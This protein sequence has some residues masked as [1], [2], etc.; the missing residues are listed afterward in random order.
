MINPIEQCGSL[1]AEIRFGWHL[2]NWCNYKCS[3]CTVYDTITNDFTIDAHTKD[4][5][6]TL[7]KL[8]LFDRP[9]NICLTGGETSLHPRIFEII[10]ELSK[11]QMLTNIWFFTN[12]S[13]SIKFYQQLNSIKSNKI[14]LYASYH[15]EYH[16]EKFIEKCIILNDKLR[17]SVHLSLSD[18]PDTWENT[19]SVIESLRKNNIECRLNLL[20]PTPNWKPNYDDN[21]F[22]IFY[23]YL[24]KEQTEVNEIPCVFNDGT[25]KIMRDYEISMKQYNNFHNYKCV[26]GTF[27]IGIDGR[28]TNTCT[29]K[30]MPALLK[31]KT[32][33]TEERC[34]KTTCDKMLLSYY[35]KK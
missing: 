28:I 7:A 24:D 9:W 29:D 18:K 13:R 11:M 12:L 35:R 4:Y 33:I 23:K 15:P 17:F 19:I 16:S 22:D 10:D 32:I 26:P 34:P 21:F 20:S 2:T 1:D 27:Q 14:V 6:I 31:S 25:T 3:Y 5:K 8:K 30:V